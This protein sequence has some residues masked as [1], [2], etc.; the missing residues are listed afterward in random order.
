MS[1]TYRGDRTIDGLTVTVD[2]A[3]LPERTDIKALSSDGFEWSY[4]GSAPAQLAL[5]LLAD[6][7]GDAGRALQLYQPFMQHVVANF[8]NEWEMTSA[9]IAEA[10]AALEAPDALAGLM[11][12]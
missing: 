1:R 3:P 10:V 12:W 9:D 2:G 11:C 5:A 6:H 7:F 8:D 4:E